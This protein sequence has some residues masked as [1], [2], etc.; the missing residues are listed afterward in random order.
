MTSTRILLC[1]ATKW[2]TEPL[3]KAF[4]GND[5]VTILKTGIGAVNAD[6]ALRNWHHAARPEDRP[7]IVVSCGLCGALQPG[8]NTGDIVADLSGAE[9]AWAH[10]ARETAAGLKLGI[11]F[12]KIIHSDR[13]LTTPAEKARLGQEQRASAV[14]MESAAIRA[15]ARSAAMSAL[16]IRVVLDGIN[17]TLPET[18]PE[19]EDFLSLTKYAFTNARRLPRLAAIGVQQRTAMTNLSVFLKAY[20]EHL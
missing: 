14:D 13:V 20:L 10:A 12:G 18:M 7:G 19:G 5:R 11:H 8:M 3:V 2:E 16:V 1:T 15:F 4:K 6:M 17:D 9:S